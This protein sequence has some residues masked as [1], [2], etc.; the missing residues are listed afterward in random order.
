M[1]H[2]NGEEFP[3]HPNNIWGG[4]KNTAKWTHWATILSKRFQTER[5]ICLSSTS[6][7][8]HVQNKIPGFG[9][10]FHVF[11]GMF[12]LFSSNLNFYAAARQVHVAFWRYVLRYIY[13]YICIY[14]YMYIYIHIYIY[15]CVEPACLLTTDHIARKHLPA[16]GT[17]S[18]WV[19][20]WQNPSL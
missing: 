15:V 13:I 2:W 19:E 4:T 16:L 5:S 12:G 9:H 20:Q 8:G 18:G 7:V 1:Y 6:L 17:G 10:P 11:R 14:I 3:P